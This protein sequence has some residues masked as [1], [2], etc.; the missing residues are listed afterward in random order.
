MMCD[1][2]KTPGTV[3]CALWEY[4]ISVGALSFMRCLVV[5]HDERCAVLCLIT[6]KTHKLKQEIA[7]TRVFISL[8][9][10]YTSLLCSSRIMHTDS[11]L[12]PTSRHLHNTTP[13]VPTTPNDVHTFLLSCLDSFLYMQRYHNPNFS[14]ADPFSTHSNGSERQHQRKGE[15]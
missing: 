13:L 2:N 6:N 7:G 15:G 10:A 1:A 8:L 11:I 5:L 14:D 3:Y 12:I 4:S 9:P